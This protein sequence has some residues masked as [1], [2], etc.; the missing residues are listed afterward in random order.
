[1]NQRFG[2]LFSV[3]VGLVQD[4]RPLVDSTLAKNL[5]TETLLEPVSSLLFA[6]IH[7]FLKQPDSTEPKVPLHPEIT[8]LIKLQGQWVVDNKVPPRTEQSFADMRRWGRA[9]LPLKNTIETRAGVTF[10]DISLPARGGERRVRVYRPESGTSL[11]TIIFINGGGYAVGSIED[12][13]HET[14]RLAASIPANVVSIR[15]RLAPEHP[16][17]AGVDDGEDIL[18]AITKGAIPGLARE[19][20]AVGGISAGAGLAVAMAQ[21][22][23]AKGRSPIDLLILMSPWLD[24]TGTL[25]SVDV[26]GTGYFLEKPSLASFTNAYLGNGVTAD[27]PELSPARHPVPAHWPQTILLS[28][29]CDPLADDAALF[30]RRLA[31]S[32]IAHTWRVARGMTHAFHA[33]VG[34]VPAAVPETD[35]MDARI[36]AWAAGHSVTA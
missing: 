33:W 11:P 15:Y 24:M 31:E 27:H 22:A 3:E 35:W 10:E 25:P 6:L 4:H 2:A 32:D 17:P 13:H 21:R 14:L 29:E 36:R 12:T 16:W 7:D 20:I 19:R 23:L 18:D 5:H 30:A 28:A 1:M 8:A 9:Q 34:Q 26:F